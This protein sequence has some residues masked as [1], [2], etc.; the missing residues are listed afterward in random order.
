MWRVL[1]RG[2]TV[3]HIFLSNCSPSYVQTR[4][5]GVGQEQKHGDKSGYCN[6]S[7]SVDIVWTRVGAVEGKRSDWILE[8]F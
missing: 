6:N 2:V 3:A 5:L 4:V 8:I 1:G 7:A